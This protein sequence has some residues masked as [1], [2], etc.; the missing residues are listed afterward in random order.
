[1]KSII[2]STEEVQ[3]ILDGRKSQFR[4]V[5]DLK[6]NSLIYTGFLV[7][8]TDKN[9]VGKC[10]FGRNKERDLE[11][12]KP[13]YKI[14]DMLYVKEKFQLGKNIRDIQNIPLSYDIE[15]LYYE[16][17]INSQ[18]QNNRDFAEVIKWSPSIHLKEKDARIFLKITNVRV[19]RLQDI[20]TL[21]FFGEGFRTRLTAP[22]MEG[23][24]WFSTIWN[25]KTKDGYKWEDNPYVFVYEF[26]RVEK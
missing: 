17:E 16:K 20:K 3:A 25:K 10:C 18:N 14:D 26:E 5:I 13:K 23:R 24:G 1:M 6:D 7:N 22:Y 15:V 8:S 2:F 12:K 11:F 4:K 19:G 9:K 21:D